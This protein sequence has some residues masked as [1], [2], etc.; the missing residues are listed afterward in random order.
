MLE[1]AGAGSAQD[2]QSVR[3]VY[4]EKGAVARAGGCDRGQRCEVPVHA[5]DAVR[6]DERAG[7]TRRELQLERGGVA[8]RV[9]VDCGARDAAGIDQRRVVEAVAEDG[10]ALP[11]H[12]RREPEVRHIA[13]REKE[14][15][16]APGECREFLFERLVLALVTR[17]EV[18]GARADTVQPSR[19]DERLGH[20]RMRSEA[21]VIVA[22]EIDAAL[23]VE[24]DL[25][26]VV[27][28]APDVAT[29][30]AETL[31]V[32]VRKHGLECDR[33]GRHGIS[34]RLRQA[35]AGCRAG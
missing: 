32:E 3:V 20:A 5:E 19:L 9:V 16:R 6:Q 28:E 18:R 17:D 25:G 2:A 4:G 8:V 14:C 31:L 35:R 22:A 12:G 13:G 30:A 1:R 27:G 15:A 26:G 10:V 29:P 34:L 23:P 21:E 33:R 24:L 11:D 7:R